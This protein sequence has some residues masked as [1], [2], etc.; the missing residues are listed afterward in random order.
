[1][2]MYTYTH[3]H[4]CIYNCVCARARVCMTMRK[5]AGLRSPCTTRF[6]CTTC[7]ATH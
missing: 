5:L 1:M 4:K 7:T 6:S 2:Y 3:T